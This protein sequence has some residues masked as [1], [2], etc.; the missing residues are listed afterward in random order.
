MSVSVPPGYTAGTWNIDPIHSEVSFS[1][2]HLGIAKVRGRFDSFE[3][4]IVTGENPLDSSVTATIQASSVS[5]RSEQRDA[6]LRTA[7]FLH[8]E[9][10]PE[11]KFTSTGVRANGDAFLVDG[12]LS[13]RGVTRPVTLALEVNGFGKGYQGGAMAGFSASTEISRTEF[14]ITGGPAGSMIG[15]T[16]T[17]T[18]EAEATQP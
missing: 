13:L 1:V 18:L 10:F 3:G 4:Q 14:G 9:E 15:E 2:K 11:M 12:D 8:T 5:T 7:E 17:I 16:I 6:H